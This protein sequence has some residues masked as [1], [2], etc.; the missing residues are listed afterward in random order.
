MAKILDVKNTTFAITS[1]L[2]YY[3]IRSLRTVL[4]DTT[5]ALTTS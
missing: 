3:G 1:V 5:T 2:N 4:Y